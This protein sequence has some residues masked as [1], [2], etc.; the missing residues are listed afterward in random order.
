MLNQAKRVL[1]LLSILLPAMLAGATI[2]V[3]LSPYN[4]DKT[5]TYD[6]TIAIQSAINYATAHGDNIYL[7]AGVYLI[8]SHLTVTNNLNGYQILIYGNGRTND[9]NG[10]IIRATTNM[11][12]MLLHYGNKIDLY[13]IRFEGNQLAKTII[14]SG[15]NNLDGTSLPKLRTITVLG[16]TEIAV[17]SKIRMKCDGVATGVI[18]YLIVDSC[19]AGVIW[20]GNTNK[21]YTTDGEYCKMVVD[22]LRIFNTGSYVY[23]TLR[24]GYSFSSCDDFLITNDYA[25]NTN[26]PGLQSAVCFMYNSCLMDGGYYDGVLRGPTAGEGCHN[27]IIRNYTVKNCSAGIS[28]DL[29]MP[30]C[31]ETAIYG[32][33]IGDNG[34]GGRLGGTVTNNT[35][36]ACSRA[37]YCQGS[38][39]NF[40]NNVIT[41]CPGGPLYD[42]H[43]T[44]ILRFNGS[45]TCIIGGGNT[46]SGLNNKRIIYATYNVGEP[47]QSEAS[48]VYFYESLNDF[49]NT[50]SPD[51]AISPS[52]IIIEPVRKTAIL[53][54]R[55]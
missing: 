26:N 20:Y 53:T 7:P 48:L 31:I 33:G 16:A 37:W 15:L 47:D 14:K 43:N 36:D 41:N 18:S 24:Y 17:W 8:S 40:T 35:I 11:N 30:T 4:A 2:D 23:G 39:I 55:F 5:G 38:D 32:N 3:T 46:I 22:N 19:G 27:F 29:R 28:T 13:K 12:E 9:A 21:R 52:Q 54:N 44:G 51:I 10:T 42:G 49:E 50:T 34:L 1:L 6:A 25:Y 45:Q